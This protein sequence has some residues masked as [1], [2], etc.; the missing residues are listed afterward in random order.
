[1]STQIVGGYVMRLTLA[2]AVTCLSWG[3]AM[4]DEGHHHSS[5]EESHHSGDMKK[6]SGS[7][8][9]GMQ[10]HTS[11]SPLGMKKALGLTDEQVKALEPVD[12]GYRKMM[13]K[14]GADLRVAMI[15][16]GTLLDQQE[17]D[18]AAV[19]QTV[20]EIGGLQ[21]QLMMFRVDTLFKLKDILTPNQYQQFRAQLKNQMS[22][23][24]GS[25]SHG[26]GSMSDHGS[27]GK[28]GYGKGHSEGY[29]HGK[30]LKH[31]H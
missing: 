6:H 30:D 23:G 28:H 11:V 29:G 18:R 21:K 17:T 24:S 2:L 12:S 8:H 27:M 15:D 20:D 26:M 5:K 3:V 13:I 14:N 22:R 7:A 25:G 31:G 1:M 9:G 10:H 16:L 4:A 19:S